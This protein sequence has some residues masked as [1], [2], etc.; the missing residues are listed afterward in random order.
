MLFDKKEISLTSLSN[1]LSFK[2]TKYFKKYHNHD[3]ELAHKQR[4]MQRDTLTDLAPEY[5]TPFPTPVQ[6]T[7]VSSPTQ[8][9]SGQLQKVTGN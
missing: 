2:I 4:L 5:S 8:M 6:E 7:L 1:N 3:Q 9:L